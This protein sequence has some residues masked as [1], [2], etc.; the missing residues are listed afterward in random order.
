MNYRSTRGDGASVSGAQAIV[1]GIAPDGG[2]YLPDRWPVLTLAEQQKMA[3]MK[4]AGRSFE[5]LRRF[6]PEL[7]GQELEEGIQ[8]GY[9]VARWSSPE[10]VPTVSLND[11][12]SVMEIWHGPTHA[13][14]DVALQVLPYLLRSS[15]RV[16][17]DQREV[18]ILVAT[19]G[20]TGKA[21]L[22]G[23]KDVPGTRIMV[24]YPLDG[25]SRIQA[26]QMLTQEGDNTSVVG[27]YGNFDDAQTGVKKIFTDP[28]WAQTLSKYNMTFSSANSI[29]WG[30]LAPQIAYYFSSYFDLV[31]VGK[32]AWGDAINF[33]VPTGN[34]GNI[35]AGYIAKTMGLPVHRLIC[36]SNRNRILTDFIQSGTYDRN[37]EFY[38]TTSPSMDI[39]IS[40]NLER[41]LFL[42]AGE[43]PSAICKWMAELKNEGRYTLDSQ[44]K[45]RLNQV[46]WGGWCDDGQTLAEIKRTFD[47]HHYL[48]DTHTAVGLK[49]YRDYQEATGDDHPTV[50]ASTAN[51]FKFNQAVAQA[52][53]GPDAGKG[54]DEFELLQTVANHAGVQ[55][56]EGLLKL[57]NKPILHNTVA[58]PE[59]MSAAVA[60]WL[61]IKEQA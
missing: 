37:R 1:S 19:S 11:K 44:T 58:K 27:V 24:F 34:F 57:R 26:L 17:G 61:K 38:T 6:L 31:Q 23:F 48:V 22:E 10:I 14:K 16:T 47:A 49:V 20:D 32:I 7:P 33:V 29:N 8:K 43:D 21:A 13:F 9:D 59:G 45:D 50:V 42:L 60:N 52:L 28:V 56:P 41:L 55:V 39:L 12:L 40:S 54:R 25:V 5:V 3:G 46:F 18:I 15:L 30:R 51:P 53:L 36:A 4:F 35:L 2:L